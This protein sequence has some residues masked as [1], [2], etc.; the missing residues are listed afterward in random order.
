MSANCDF[1]KCF[2]FSYL[3]ANVKSDRSGYERI[4]FQRLQILWVLFIS[5]CTA[6]TKL[7]TLVFLYSGEF[8]KNAIEPLVSLCY[9]HVNG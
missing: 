8:V 2:Q 3:V 6:K 7:A 1:P 5:Y 9:I 4:A